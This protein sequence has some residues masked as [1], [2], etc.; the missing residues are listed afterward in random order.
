MAI[1]TAIAAA[2]VVTPK[3]ADAD[4]GALILGVDE[5]TITYVDTGMTDTGA[6]GAREEDFV[7]GLQITGIN[8]GA[9]TVLSLAG[10]T[11]L[12]ANRVANH[13]LGE[14]TAIEAAR[15]VT[16]IAVAV[17]EILQGKINDVLTAT[18]LF[19]FRD[20]G[21]LERR[22]S[23]LLWQDFLRDRIRGKKSTG[24][25]QC[26]DRAFRKETARAS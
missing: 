14:P 16:T 3:P 19:D 8:P 1:G 25:S 2:I 21:F 17:S 11:D 26:A 20:L 24:G 18:L 9:G 12:D 5:L 4:T 13:E 15:G 22:I 7:T 6:I 23:D 10:V